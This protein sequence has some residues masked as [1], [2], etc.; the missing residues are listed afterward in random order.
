MH[1][2]VLH[3]N[4]MQV[5]VLNCHHLDFA[6]KVP[7]EMLTM[8][9]WPVRTMSL[10]CLQTCIVRRSACAFT[11]GPHARRARRSCSSAWARALSRWTRKTSHRLPSLRPGACACAPCMQRCGGAWPAPRSARLMTSRR[12]PHGGMGV[13]HCSNRLGACL[14]YLTNGTE[15]MPGLGLQPQDQGGGRTCQRMGGLFCSG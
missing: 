8:R 5:N 14:K 10:D 9:R 13:S 3:P 1:G 11:A 15:P 12:R 4:F 7:A 2:T 6:V